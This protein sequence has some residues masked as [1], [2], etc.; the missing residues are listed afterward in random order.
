MP[1]YRRL[2]KLV[3]KGLGRDG[4]QKANFG[5]VKLSVLNKC[6]DNSEVRCLPRSLLPSVHTAVSAAIRVAD[7]SAE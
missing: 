3:G 4:H 7:P 1:L 5:L 6:A 2:P